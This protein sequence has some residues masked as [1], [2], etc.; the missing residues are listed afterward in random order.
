MLPLW[1][2][3]RS[4]L[5]LGNIDDSRPIEDKCAGIEH[6]YTN[7]FA[8]KEA[9]PE[10]WDYE[11]QDRVLEYIVIW[12]N[13]DAG[14]RCNLDPIATQVTST[15]EGA[16]VSPSD[17]SER[18]S[19]S[20]VREPA[21]RFVSAY[22]EVQGN[23]IGPP[24]VDAVLMPNGTRQETF[25][26]HDVAST[27][28]ASAFVEDLLTFRILPPA[29]HP[30]STYDHMLFQLAPMMHYNQQFGRPVD[31]VGHL[32][33][34]DGGWETIEAFAN[35]SFP[36]FDHEC[37]NHAT[38]NAASGNP[39]RDAMEQLISDDTHIAHALGCA[40][41]LPDFV[42]MGYTNLVDSSQCEEAGFADAVG[43]PWTEVVSFL[44]ATLCPEVRNM[45]QLNTL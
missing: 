22:S 9:V 26:Q 37:E 41:L 34:F 2:N 29:V 1:D 30:G 12:K 3:A 13:A 5:S 35:V 36:P 4:G 11:F 18:L 20:Y 25:T 38:T 45:T 40:V 27:A 24:G 14:I 7:G 28:A 43:M 21:G 15:N 19:F 16:T 44:R 31:F 32:E 42:C 10:F 8:S 23:M 33:D 17:T 6:F 39:W